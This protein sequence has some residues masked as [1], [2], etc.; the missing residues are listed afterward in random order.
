[1]TIPRH[2]LKADVGKVYVRFWFRCLRCN[3]YMVTAN[4]L[5]GPSCSCGSEHLE[6]VSMESW[7]WL[8][9]WRRTLRTYKE[10]AA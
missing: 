8:G 5:T 6:N 4:S 2:L 1:M 7:A 9:F 10:L 3:E